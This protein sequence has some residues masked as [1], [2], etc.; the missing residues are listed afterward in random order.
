MLEIGDGLNNLSNEQIETSQRIVI[1]A[2]M[3]LSRV[4]DHLIVMDGAH[5]MQ[6]MTAFI[7]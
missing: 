6:K 1:P 5:N 4:N 3:D 2:R 7:S